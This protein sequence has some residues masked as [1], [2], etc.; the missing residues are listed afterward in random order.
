VLFVGD[1]VAGAV[2]EVGALSALET[3]AVQLLAQ[4]VLV[5]GAD[6]QVVEYLREEV[7][8]GVD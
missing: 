7:A 3:V 6:A 2:E 5:K 8:E 4:V 1:K